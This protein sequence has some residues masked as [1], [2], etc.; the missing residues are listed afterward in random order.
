MEHHAAKRQ[1]PPSLPS[2]EYNATVATQLHA[3]VQETHDLSCPSGRPTARKFPRFEERD[4]G[5]V[6]FCEVRHRHNMTMS[7]LT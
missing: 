3:R 1:R 5:G 4:R 7:D 6:T 2:E